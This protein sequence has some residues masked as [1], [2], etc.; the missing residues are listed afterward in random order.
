MSASETDSNVDLYISAEG[1]PPSPLLDRL[2]AELSEEL[3]TTA[4]TSSTLLET[5]RERAARLPKLPSRLLDNTAPTT[6]RN[7]VVAPSKTEKARSATE[8]WFALP[9]PILTP[10]LKRDLQLVQ[11]RAALDPKRHYKKEKWVAPERF[12]VGTIV[13]GSTEYFSLRMKRKARGTTLVEEA[14]K[15]ADTKAYM[16]RKYT[17]VVDKR[18]SGKRGHYKKMLEKRRRF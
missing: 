16:K 18:A 5:L 12:H 8:L 3:G 6:Q 15:N 7:P 14:L 13:E 10:Q 9:K 17:E 1:S 11:Q 2:F 4:P